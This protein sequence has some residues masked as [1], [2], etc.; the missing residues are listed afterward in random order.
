MTGHRIRL[1]SASHPSP[2]AGP[3]FVAKYA[4]AV[5]AIFISEPAVLLAEAI[6]SARLLA[7][8]VEGGL[9][10]H[11]VSLRLAQCLGEQVDHPGVFGFE[12]RVPPS[13]PDD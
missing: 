5:A 7:Q 2:P 8:G 9:H 1:P 11:T 10:H 12:R 13:P 4:L 6:V 3:W